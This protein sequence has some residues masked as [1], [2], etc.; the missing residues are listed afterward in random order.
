M[1]RK[2][3]SKPVAKRPVPESSR[4]GSLAKETE[5]RHTGLVAAIWDAARQDEELYANQQQNGRKKKA[6]L[7]SN[8]PSSSSSLVVRVDPPSAFESGSHCLFMLMDVSPYVAE[9][10]VPSKTHAEMKQES[11]D[12]LRQEGI[13]MLETMMIN[14]YGSLSMWTLCLENDMVVMKAHE[15]TLLLLL[16]QLTLKSTNMIESFFVL[17]KHGLVSLGPIIEDEHGALKIGVCVTERAF[18][19][20]RSYPEDARGSS[21][22]RAMLEVLSCFGSLFKSTME[23]DDEEEEDVLGDV[24]VQSPIIV[25]S[26]SGLGENDA[27]LDAATLY[28]LIKPTGKEPEYKGRLPS[29][30]PILHGYQRRVLNWMIQRENNPDCTAQM[31]LEDP[32]S[33]LRVHVSGRN[34]KGVMIHSVSVSDMTFLV[35]RYTGMICRHGEHRESLGLRGGIA[36]DEMGL[37]KT[38]EMLA[39]IVA[40]PPRYVRKT[41]SVEM[42]EKRMK[43]SGIHEISCMCGVSGSFVPGDVHMPMLI[44][45]AGC[46]LWSHRHCNGLNSFSTKTNWKC[47]KCCSMEVME[48]ALLESGATLIVCPVPILSQWQSEIDK[49]VVSGTLKVVTYLGQEQ[50]QSNST[51]DMVRPR[52]LADADIVLTTYDALRHDLY[53][54]PERFA[55]R[56]LRYEKRYHVVPTPLTSIKFWRIVVDEA[57]MVESSTAKATEMVKKI[58]ST[59]MWCVTGTPISRGLEDLYGLFSF[60]KVDPY[61]FRG[62]WSR[63]IQHPLESKEGYKAALSRLIKLLKPSYGGVMWR[64]S[65][66]DVAGE[67]CIPKQSTSCSSVSFSNI[68]KHFYDKQHQACCGVARAALNRASKPGRTKQHADENSSGKDNKNFMNG[69]ED[70]LLTKREE[71]KLLL[72]LLRLRQA[73]VHPQVGVGG[74]KSLS[75]VKTPMSMIQVLQVM[76]GKSKVEAEDAQR[77][78]LSTINGLAGIKI[79]QQSFQDAASEYR[80]VLKIS[81]CNEDLIKADKLQIL[82]TLVNLQQLLNKPGVGKTTEDDTFENRIKSLEASYLLEPSTR[83]QAQYSDLHQI[84]NQAESMLKKLSCKTPDLKLIDYWWV[85]AIH[86]IKEQSGDNGEQFILDLKRSLSQDDV[87]RQTAS[88]NASNLAERFTDLFGLQILLGQE[89]SGEEQARKEVQSLLS[90]LGKRVAEE[91]PSLIDAAAHCAT[92]RSFNAIGGIVCDHCHFDKSMIAW[93]V[94]LF[95]LVATARGKAELSTDHIAEAAHKSSLYR[96]GVGGV[97]EKGLLQEDHIHGK[98]TDKKVAD[99]KIIR[100]PSQA[101]KILRHLAN[102]LRT[103]YGHQKEV[104][105]EQSM[106]LEASKCHLDL[107][108]LRKKEYIKIGAVASAQRHVLYA[109]DE[110]NMSRMRI[111]LRGDTQIVSPEEERYMVHSLEIPNKL[112]EF[113]NEYIIAQAEM[114]KALGTLKYLKTLE[115]L[116]Q[117]SSGVQDTT[118][119]AEPC[120][121]CHES[122]ADDLAMLPCGHILCVSCNIRIIEKENRSKN[123]PIM[124]CPTCR[125]V[126]PASETAVVTTQSKEQQETHTHQDKK[127]LWV[128]ENS[129]EIKGSFGSKI[130]AILKRIMIVRERR[131]NDKIIVF[132]SW[133]DALDI[134]AYALEQNAQKYLHPK[135]GK[136]FDRD[137]SLFRNRDSLDTPRILLL[138]LKQGGNGLNLQ[139]AQHVIFVEPVMDPGEEAQA[140]GRVDRMGQEKET[141]IHKFIVLDSIEENVLRINEQKKLQD[142][143]KSKH[144][145]QSKQHLSLQEVS[146]LLK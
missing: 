90:H 16:D 10:F 143:I 20:L 9:S 88:R 130:E 72:P 131:P 122:L 8:Q 57:Q 104:R 52:D 133:K 30:K 112:Q 63:L 75:H 82:H 25:S 111:K 1:A 81:K 145:N 146:A 79:L 38:V 58:A 62:W 125:A 28:Q 19:E 21:K 22:S 128:G 2:K 84:R 33:C 116:N 89:L 95:T 121:V 61:C 53:R 66:V 96:V 107:I 93:E 3:Q 103:Q 29:L 45:C 51:V 100:G 98:R 65:K 32:V 71:R 60:L 4:A 99:S 80:K 114:Q 144:H 83:L 124:K 73:C 55:G 18:V 94:R 40:N 7:D 126:A 106:L 92:C 35:N 36:C 135:G 91:D 115:R 23:G 41:D 101:E 50:P 108:E 46:S 102:S 137:V 15:R 64:S 87:Y 31:S 120:P 134:L 119:Q 17:L 141:F 129:I 74:L 44:L 67:I 49:H 140:I 97:G 11:D 34:E 13:E 69:S 43:E 110:L 54:N 70:R 12:P 85:N 26:E 136:M 14:D 27:E 117:N 142:G 5:L 68:E 86:I 48:S 139:Q 76:I 39:L 37:G 24:G 56:S 77:L 42:D 138:L 78:L 105:A 123:D 47:S 6:K 132:S 113:E 109:L 59:N 118:R 127:G